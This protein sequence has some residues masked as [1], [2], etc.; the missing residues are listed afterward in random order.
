[1]IETIVSAAREVL[2]V[3]NEG[4]NEAPEEERQEGL[5]ILRNPVSRV[6]RYESKRSGFQE[7][8]LEKGLRRLVGEFSDRTLIHAI[9]RGRLSS[10]QSSPHGNGSRGGAN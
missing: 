7:L 3:V 8:Y 5:F 1:M 10:C 2:V 6:V 9:N 4:I